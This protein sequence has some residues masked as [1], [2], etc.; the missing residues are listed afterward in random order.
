MFLGV[1]GGAEVTGLG[2]LPKTDEEIVE[3]FT[4]LLDAA[5]ECASLHRL[6]NVAFHV[7]LYSSDNVVDVA[8]L[9]VAEAEVLDDRYGLAGET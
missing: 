7:P 5:A 6:V 2:Q 8:S 9:G 4:W 1:V 3:G